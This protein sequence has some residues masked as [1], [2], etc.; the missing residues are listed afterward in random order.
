[1]AAHH[2]KQPPMSTTSSTPTATTPLAIMG[3]V[4]L[5]SLTITPDVMP[6]HHVARAVILDLEPSQMVAAIMAT[7]QAIKQTHRR[8]FR[9][10][11]G[12]YTRRQNAHNQQQ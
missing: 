1:M 2:E 5:E 11:W 3:G 4:V 7:E 12:D 8:M 10:V 9:T 6:H